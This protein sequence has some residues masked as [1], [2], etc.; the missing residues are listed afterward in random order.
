MQFNVCRY[1]VQ[2]GRWSYAIEN[3]ALVCMLSIASYKHYLYIYV[4][5]LFR[6]MVLYS[7]ERFYR[8]LNLSFFDTMQCELTDKFIWCYQWLY[9]TFNSNYALVCMFLFVPDCARYACLVIRQCY[10]FFRS[11]FDCVPMHWLASSCTVTSTF[12]WGMD[13]YACTLVCGL[14]LS[15]A[16]RW[17]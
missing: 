9:L 10:A 17:H 5:H 4:M 2:L 16:I 6:F 14:C 1:I 8:P 11:E 7:V 15:G 13:T 12:E 3:F